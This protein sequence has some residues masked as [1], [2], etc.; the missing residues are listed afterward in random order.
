MITIV[1]TALKVATSILSGD[2]PFT[3]A[4]AKVHILFG[5][6]NTPYSVYRTVRLLFSNFASEI[7]LLFSGWFSP[8]VGDP[9]FGF[10]NSSYFIE[11]LVSG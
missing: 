3:F 2:T 8:H 4:G 9:V 7:E 11:L 10:S 5:S 6:H 1:A